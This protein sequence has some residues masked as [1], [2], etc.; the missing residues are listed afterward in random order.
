MTH[1]PAGVIRALRAL[2]IIGLTISAAPAA[3]TATPT[4]LVIHR[5]YDGAVEI[6]GDVP[7][8]SYSNGRLLVE[9]TDL[10]ADGIFR[11][12]FEQ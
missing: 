5:T 9:I 12:G 6:A 1:F 4:G 11:N 3:T 10:G 7:F 2:V 8:I